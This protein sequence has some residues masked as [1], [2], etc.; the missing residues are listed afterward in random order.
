MPA[1]L[2]WLTLLNSLRFY[3]VI[4]RGIFLKGVG[5][6]VLWTQLFA[7]AAIGLAV[8]LVAVERFKKTVA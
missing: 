1:P 8:L 2:Q 7:L 6:G 5:V 3:M 4:I